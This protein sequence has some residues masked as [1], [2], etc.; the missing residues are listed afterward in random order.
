MGVVDVFGDAK[1]LAPLPANVH[2]HRP[3]LKQAS[4]AAVRSYPALNV[5]SATKFVAL[6]R[7][8][9]EAAIGRER[10]T[11]GE[12][13]LLLK[14][15]L[16]EAGDMQGGLKWESVAEGL[17]KQFPRSSSR[18]RTSSGMTTDSGSQGTG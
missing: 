6:H 4:Q 8:Q 12:T 18:T 11:R 9:S 15:D 14:T 1:V 17:R 2:D 13:S 3:D 16:W 10:R 7:L 5:A